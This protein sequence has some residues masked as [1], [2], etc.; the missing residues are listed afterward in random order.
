MGHLM[1]QKFRFVFE[2]ITFGTA[3]YPFCL[4]VHVEFR[5]FQTHLLV[6]ELRMRF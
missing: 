1:Y 2:A 6:D 5:N 3:L 4:N